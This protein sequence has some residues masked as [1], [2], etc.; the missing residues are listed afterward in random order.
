MVLVGFDSLRTLSGNKPINTNQSN[1]KKV[2]VISMKEQNIKRGRKADY[3]DRPLTDD[4][5]AFASDENNY[6]QL[7]KFMRVNRLNPDEWYDILIIPYLQAVKKYCSREDLHIYPFHAISNKVLS[8]AVHHH[9]K[10]MHTQKRMPVGGF[11]SLDYMMEGDNPFSEYGVSEW[12]IDRK[13]S[14]EN[15]V[16]FKDLFLTFYKQCISYEDDFWGENAINDYLKKELDLLLA[17]YTL[18][19]INRKTEKVYPYGYT[20]SDLEYDIK[21]IQDIFKQVF[22]S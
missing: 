22:L 18:K 8:C 7:F 3:T 5:R 17:G 19:Q 11:V 14:V 16:I 9:Y 2:E 6:N 1:H 20:V 10:A 4:E 15:S 13:I 21:K 12:W